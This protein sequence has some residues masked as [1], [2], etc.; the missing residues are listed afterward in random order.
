VATIAGNLMVKHTWPRFPSDIFLLFETVGAM[1]EV[2]EYWADIF[3]I[4]ESV[5]AK[6]EGSGYWT[7]IFLKFE[8]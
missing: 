1:L 6:V 5:A 7:D 4:F 3:L 8:H 2:S